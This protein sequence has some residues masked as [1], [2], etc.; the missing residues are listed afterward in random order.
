MPRSNHWFYLTC[1]D[2]SN[3]PI[4]FLHGFMGAGSDW[5]DIAAQLEHR[6]FCLLP[7]L[8][9]HGKTTVPDEW[10]HMTFQ[11]VA[12]ELL[13]FIRHLTL[14]KPVLAGYSMGGRIALYSVL[15][16]PGEFS[17]LVL[18]G[19]NPGISDAGKR[20]DRA[21]SDHRL[22]EQLR[23]DGIQQFVKAWYDQPLFQSLRTRSTS[24]AQLLKKRSVNDPKQLAGILSSLSQ[25]RQPDMWNRLPSISIP[26]LLLSGSDDRRYSEIHMRMAATLQISSVEQITGAGHNAH[27]EQPD[28]FALHLM[29]FLNQ[30]ISF[31]P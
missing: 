6:F 24:H 17:A 13:Q 26:V 14:D 28:T 5:S 10:N 18:E 15:Q 19:G 31:E 4:I 12:Q 30:H 23:E 9:G 7:D 8:P 27:L 25:G 1:G 29:S 16:Y 22:A 11:R 3:P 2:H 20:S 21:L